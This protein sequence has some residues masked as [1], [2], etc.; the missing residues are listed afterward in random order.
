MSD[1]AL[2][3][4]LQFLS[5]ILA[6]GISGLVEFGFSDGL[7]MNAAF[8][9]VAKNKASLQLAARMWAQF[10]Q[11]NPHAASAIELAAAINPG[12]AA[13]LEKIKVKPKEAQDVEVKNTEHG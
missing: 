9:N 6:R 7:K 1:E 2:D 8:K 11:V 3:K 4:D 13:F 12:L 5:D 10:W